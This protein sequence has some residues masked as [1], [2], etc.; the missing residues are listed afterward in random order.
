[1]TAAAIDRQFLQDT[2]LKFLGIH[3]PTGYTDPIVREVCGELEKLNIPFDLTRRGAIRATLPG[4]LKG[5]ARAVVVHLDTLGA[6]TACLKDNGRLGLVPVG[7]WSARFAEGARVSIFSDAMIYRGSILPLK[8]SGHVYNEA[9]DTQPVAWSNLEV[10]VDERSQSRA[11]LDRLGIRVGDFIGV[12]AGAEFLPNGFLVARHLDNKAGVAML[13]AVAAFIRRSSI[14][15]PLTTY[16]LFTIS[17]EVGIGASAVLHGDVAEMVT[18]D[19][20]TCAPGQ[21]SSEFGATIAMADSSGPFDFHLTH[22]LLHLCEKHGIPH[23]RDIFRHYR[24]DSASAVEAGN[25]IRTALTAFGVDASHGYER[26]HLDALDAVGRLV[27]AYLQSDPLQSVRGDLV[28]GLKHFPST[29]TV[30][31]GPLLHEEKTRVAQE[32]IDPSAT[33]GKKPAREKSARPS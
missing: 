26:T 14:Q 24:C 28:R 21:S 9:V 7:T 6:M 13:L 32:P 5:P 22:H 25:D 18:I 12:D 19:N 20:G 15:L 3:S 27:V 33:T 30:P 8:A 23:V 2:L 11:D 16:L 4:K 31:V 1:M 10:R 17:E 29:R